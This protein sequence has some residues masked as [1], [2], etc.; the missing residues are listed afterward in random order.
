MATFRDFV[1]DYYRGAY[2]ETLRLATD[3][4]DDLKTLHALLRNVGNGHEIDLVRILGSRSETVA[5]LTLRRA[6]DKDGIVRLSPHDGRESFEWSQDAEGWLE[7][8][9]L[10]EGMFEET[11]GCHQ[12]LTAERSGRVIVEVAFREGAD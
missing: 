4:P 8:A 10:V 2:G 3:T 5:R 6:T 9:E 1:I 12:Y 7:S 11:A